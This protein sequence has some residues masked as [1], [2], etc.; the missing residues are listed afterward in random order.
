MRRTNLKRLLNRNRDTVGRVALSAGAL[1][2]AIVLCVTVVPI[3]FRSQERTLTK[4]LKELGKDFYENYYFDQLGKDKEQRDELLKRYTDNG[5]Q[6]SLNNIAR[7]KVKDKDKIL[8]EFV[9]KRT[10]KSCNGSETIV[11]IIP[12]EPF[13]KEDYTIEVDLICGFRKEKKKNN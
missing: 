3:V 7:L 4:R 6:V 11:K 1:I 5:L 10:K 2:L 12:K 9:N 8:S 13:G